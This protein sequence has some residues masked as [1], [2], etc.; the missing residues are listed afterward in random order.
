MHSTLALLNKDM[1]YFFKHYVKKKTRYTFLSAKLQPNIVYTNFI[2]LKIKEH[3]DAPLYQSFEQSINNNK[4][5]IAEFLYE[6][7]SIGDLNETEW[8]RHEGGGSSENW[9]LGRMKSLK[10]PNLG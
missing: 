10:V 2:L 7:F 9:N 6:N 4:V 5:A 3:F 8:T 1:P